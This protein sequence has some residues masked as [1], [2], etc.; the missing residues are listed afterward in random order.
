MLRSP[1]SIMPN[2]NTPQST[3]SSDPDGLTPEQA[4]RMAAYRCLLAHS[5]NIP[6]FAKLGLATKAHVG[7][8]SDALYQIAVAMRRITCVS[9][10]VIVT[11]G[12]VGECFY[13]IDSGTYEAYVSGKRVTEYKGH[14]YFG[15]IALLQQASTPRASTVRCVSDGSLWS[16]DRAH[17]RQSVIGIHLKECLAC[18]P[19]LAHLSESDAQVARLSDALFEVPCQSGDVVIRQGGTRCPSAVHTPRARA[20]CTLCSDLACVCRPAYDSAP[21]QTLAT[22]STWSRMAPMRRAASMC[23]TSEA[24]SRRLLSTRQAAGMERVW[25][26]L[27]KQ[28][29]FTRPI[30]YRNSGPCPRAVHQLVPYELS[31]ESTRFDRVRCVHAACRVLRDRR[32]LPKGRSSVQRSRQLIRRPR[33]RW[34]HY[35]RRNSHLHRGGSVVG[36]RPP[37]VPAADAGR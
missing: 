15:E 3:D 8:G 20:R 7:G 22:I 30:R 33:P 17:F 36:A 12:E 37:L 13:V 19:H 28:V 18:I 26:P 4:D 2:G 32:A 35:T 11:Q 1:T 34:Q 31:A 27:M 29:T 21:P 16:L 6:C 14:G 23:I 24:A 9:G 10:D 25:S 5:M